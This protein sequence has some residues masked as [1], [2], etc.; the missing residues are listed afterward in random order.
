MIIV[1]HGEI[2]TKSPPVRKR[3]ISQ[4]ARNL[5]MVLPEAKV[6]NLYWRIAV[7]VENYELALKSI[8]RV[9]GVTTYSQCTVV[10]ANLDLITAACMQY[11]S[12]VGK[13]ETFAVNTQRLSK[14]MEM[15]SPE[16]SRHVGGALKDLTN[17]KVDLKNPGF[18]IKIEIYKGKAYISTQSFKGLGG[19]P[20]GTGEHAAALLDNEND[21]RAALLVMKRGA[22]PVFY[23]KNRKPALE[24]SVNNYMNGH[25]I[26]VHGYS[27]L[28]DV[29]QTRLGT[30]VSGASDLQTYS[31]IKNGS[32]KLVLAPLLGLGKEQL[33]YFKKL[34]EL[35]ASGSN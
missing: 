29:K 32:G 18:E 25:K 30:L 16:I 3:F 35:S 21:A 19:L 2:F 8:G 34:F 27:D 28:A 17:T 13:A 33:D 6:S 5:R 26:D 1:R 23:A 4:L 15:T 12:D 22:L 9:F 14:E 20:M 24:A 7:Y 31:R 10:E 11:E